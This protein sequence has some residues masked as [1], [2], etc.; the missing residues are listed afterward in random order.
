MSNTA[1]RRELLAAAPL[2]TWAT[3]TER[4]PL[5]ILPCLGRR[6]DRNGFPTY[7]ARGERK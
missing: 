2:R 3:S 1:S 4:V 5:A 7:P 6:Y